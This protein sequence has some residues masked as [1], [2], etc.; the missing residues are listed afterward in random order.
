MTEGHGGDNPP[1]EQ[2]PEGGPQQPGGQQP[3]GYPPQ[4]PPPQGYPPPPQGYPPPPQGYA[5]S[6]QGYP[7]QYQ[8]GYP[9]PQGYP[10]QYPAYT[11][12]PSR[13][14]NTLAVVSMWSGI[15]GLVIIPLLGSL[16]A[17]ITGHMGKRQIKERQGAEAGEGMAT[18]G[19][20]TGYL[21]I[22]FW[23]LLLVLGILIAG[24]F[25]ENAP[26]FIDELER[27]NISPP[28]PT[29]DLGI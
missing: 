21:G 11:V 9:P 19:L 14:N 16:V 29:P 6:P 25:F 12:P 10:P 2:P 15:A 3:Q 8:Q 4:G 26:E 28:P 13:P 5:P 24:W 22:A 23:G 18:A 7:P 17:V 20:V 1:P 27:L